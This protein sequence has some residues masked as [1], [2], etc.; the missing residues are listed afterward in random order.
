MMQAS[1]DRAQ[2]VHSATA[3][4]G[5]QVKATLT[6]VGRAGS[7]ALSR[8]ER[9][10]WPASVGLHA[11]DAGSRAFQVLLGLTAPAEPLPAP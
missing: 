7:E 9:A 2:C 5:E 10:S 1:N 4:G 11:L 8:I 6:E 3:Q